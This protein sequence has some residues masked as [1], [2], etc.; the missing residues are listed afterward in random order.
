MIISDLHT[1]FS[2]SLVTNL[3]TAYEWR[4]DRANYSEQ[5]IGEMPTW[6]KNMREVSNPLLNANNQNIDLDTF[7]EMQELA[8]NIVRSHF[9]DISLNKDPLA[10]IINGVAVQ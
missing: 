4:N 6:I 3:G 2:E 7:S 5:Q 1:P 10:L 9:T 8:C